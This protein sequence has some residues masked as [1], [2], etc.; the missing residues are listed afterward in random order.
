M[1]ITLLCSAKTNLIFKCEEFSH[2][3]I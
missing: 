2:F 3:I 1:K